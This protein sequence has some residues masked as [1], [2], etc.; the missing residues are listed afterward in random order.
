MEVNLFVLLKNI[1]KK[2][3]LHRTKRYT[4]LH[5]MLSR[6]EVIS[7]GLG[8]NLHQDQEQTDICTTTIA[9][10]YAVGKYIEAKNRRKWKNKARWKNVPSL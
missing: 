10:P 9:M 5:S 3:F 7:C 4:I 6:K 2:H 8:K 1:F